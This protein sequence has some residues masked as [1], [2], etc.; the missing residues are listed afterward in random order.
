V[1]DEHLVF[2]GQ[3][4]LHSQR[5]VC[6]CIVM[7]YTLVHTPFVWSLPTHVLSESPQDIAVELSIDGLTWWDRFLIDNPIIK[8][9]DQ[10]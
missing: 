9:A 10:H 4:L 7:E 3:K 8:K 6:R 5:G 1:R 2:G